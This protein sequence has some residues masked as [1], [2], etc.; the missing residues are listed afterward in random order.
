M[1]RRKTQEREEPEDMIIS[2]NS[3][4]K[5]RKNK[6]SKYFKG[7]CNNRGSY[8]HRASKCWGN[9]NDNRSDNKTAINPRFNREC[10]NCGKRGHKAVDC[11]AKKGKEKDD[12]VDN[13]FVGATFCGEVQE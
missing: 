11:W 10:N 7:E 3:G 4:E 1:N 8:G 5:K 6:S 2:L 9:K 12:E 13:L